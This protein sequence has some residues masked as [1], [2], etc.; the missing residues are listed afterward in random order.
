[1]LWP[2]ATSTA[3]I[4]SP[5]ASA[6]WF[7]SSRPSLLVWPMIGSVAF[8]RRN[9]RWM[10][11]DPAIEHPCRNLKT[12]LRYRTADT[13]AKNVRAYPFDGL[14]NVCPTSRARMQRIQ[15][16]ANIGPVGVP[17]PRCTIA[18]GHNRALD[19]EQLTPYT[20]TGRF[21]PRHDHRSAIHLTSPP[22]YSDKPSHL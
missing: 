17:S 10:V 12:A 2:A 8:R 7:G 1:M 22:G 20:L 5:S 15:N 16:L 9:S 13:A 6:R 21:S 14:M 4:A 3:L 19:A 11:G 18:S